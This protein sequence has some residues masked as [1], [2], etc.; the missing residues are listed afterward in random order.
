MKGLGNENLE[1]LHLE[2]WNFGQ[3]KGENANFFLKIEN[4]D[5]RRI[6]G[7]LVG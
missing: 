2:S 6:D 5:E 7:K 4:G 3:N 1:N